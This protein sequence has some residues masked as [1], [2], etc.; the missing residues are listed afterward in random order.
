MQAIP[1]T[2]AGHPLATRASLGL[3]NC[4]DACFACAVTCTSSAAACTRQTW[5]DELI[6]CIRLNLDCADLCDTVGRALSRQARPDW[7]ILRVE[8]RACATI[9]EACAR[10]CELHSQQFDHFAACA[11]ACR[12]CIDQFRAVGFLT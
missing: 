11:K 12:H 2:R 10:E 5:N 6:R 4:I 8:V 7:D 3:R 9:C 1:Q